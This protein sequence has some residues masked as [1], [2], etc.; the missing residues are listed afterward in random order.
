MERISILGG[1]LS[2]ES[3]DDFFL[4]ARAYRNIKKG[5]RDGD[6]SNGGRWPVL[7]RESRKLSVSPPDIEVVATVEDGESCLTENSTDTSWPDLWIFD[8]RHGWGFGDKE[9]KEVIWISKLLFLTTFDDDEF[10]HS[11]PAMVL[12]VI[13]LKGASRNSMKRLQW[14]IKAME[15]WSTL[16]I[17]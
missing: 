7:I 13:F 1:Q 11:A 4:R 5:D 12:Q 14:C 9:V 3:R 10:A 8:A 17:S 6:K 2:L 16:N 15:P